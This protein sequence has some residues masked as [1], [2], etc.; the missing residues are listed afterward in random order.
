MNHSSPGQAPELLSAR[1]TSLQSDIMANT[2][3]QIPFPELIFG[4]AGPIG[5]D[6]DLIC[7]TLA[8]ALASMDYRSVPIKLTTLMLE[9][10]ANVTAPEETDYFTDMMFKMDYAKKLC[11]DYGNAAVLSLIA[12]RAIVSERIKR[13]DYYEKISPKTAYVIRQLKRPEEVQLLRRVYG[14]QFILI[15]A[16][17][18][19]SDRKT[20]LEDKLKHSLSTATKDS[21]ISARADGL[22]ERDQS[23]GGDFGGQEL[24][25]T[26][27]LADVFIDGISKQLMTAKL[28]RFIQAFFGRTD[29]APT[30]DEYGMYAAKSASL[31]SSDLSRQVGGRCVQLGRRTDSSRLQ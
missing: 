8:A 5:V 3:D 11:A 19:A 30:K 24:R 12:I 15:S 21:D 23:E 29:I 20:L 31:R 17:G 18:A 13:T 22:I 9:F 6:V 1:H 7:E 4:I 2:L 16:Y 14:R 26:F 27:H 25:E 28:G 10:P